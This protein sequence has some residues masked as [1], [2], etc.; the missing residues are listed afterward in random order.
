[1]E[2]KSQEPNVSKDSQLQAGVVMSSSVL[3]DVETDSMC[4]NEDKQTRRKKREDDA[5]LQMMNEVEP[6]K[7]KT[8]MNSTK[9]IDEIVDNSQ[10]ETENDERRLSQSFGKTMSLSQLEK[11]NLSE[12]SSTSTSSGHLSDLHDNDLMM[13]LFEDNVNN[14]RVTSSQNST[15]MKN[16]SQETSSQNLATNDKEDAVTSSQKLKRNHRTALQAAVAERGDGTAEAFKKR[17]NQVAVRRFL[18]MAPRS[19][20]IAKVLDDERSFETKYRC[21]GDK[22]KTSERPN[23]PYPHDRDSDLRFARFVQ[24]QMYTGEGYYRN[25]SRGRSQSRNYRGP[26]AG[27]SGSTT[28]TREETVLAIDKAIPPPPKPAQ[29]PSVTDQSINELKLMLAEVIKIQKTNSES[30]HRDRSKSRHRSKHSK[31]KDHSSRKSRRSP[32]SSETS[33]SSSSSESEEDTHKKSR[34]KYSKSSKSHE[35]SKHTS[36]KNRDEKSAPSSRDQSKTR[37]SSQH[38]NGETARRSDAATGQAKKRPDSY[39]V[40]AGYAQMKK[41]Q[42]S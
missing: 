19:Y 13:D 2:N 11:L 30:R 17:L 35:K 3:Y 23:N 16:D 21:F 38:L 37:S 5:E 6:E 18:S 1:M 36:R 15:S 34:S 24:N 29:K 39:I 25:R 28:E 31:S 42:K 20:D 33:S 14:N 27:T 9:E 32:S 12:F 41:M 40:A 22:D 8:T 26:P 7:Y 4:A 10:S